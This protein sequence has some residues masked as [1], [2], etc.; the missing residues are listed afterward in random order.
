MEQPVEQEGTNP[1]GMMQDAMGGIQQQIDAIMQFADSLTQ[2]GQGEAAQ[3]FAQ[4][5]K[6]LQDGLASLGASPKQSAG[7]TGVET[8]G[9]EAQ[10][11]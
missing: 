10:P 9:R 8:G 1:E 3:K 5:A 6:M 7:M 2:A 11:V 4:G